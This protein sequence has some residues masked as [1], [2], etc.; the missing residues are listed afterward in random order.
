MA[1]LQQLSIIIF[2][3]SV[4]HP[5]R[6][7]SIPSIYWLIDLSTTDLHQFEMAFYALSS[8]QKVLRLMLHTGNETAK[9]EMKKATHSRSN[10]PWICLSDGKATKNLFYPMPLW[11]WSTIIVL[12]HQSRSTILW[13][14]SWMF[15]SENCCYKELWSRS[16][17]LQSR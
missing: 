4:P 2:C 5:T 15:Y 10:G 7:P 14:F 8:L 1:S 12:H 9:L 11:W 3:Y 16:H 17:N 6:R 13:R